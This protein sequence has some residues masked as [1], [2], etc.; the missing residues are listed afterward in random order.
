MQIV[1]IYLEC[2]SVR[3]EAQLDVGCWKLDGGSGFWVL[4][5]EVGTGS[6]E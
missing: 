3:R 6:E 4:G 2:S 1:C 5:W